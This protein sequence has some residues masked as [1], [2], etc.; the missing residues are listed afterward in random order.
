M[1]DKLSK[2]EFRHVLRDRYL[3]VVSLLVLLILFVDLVS[4]LGNGTLTLS[5]LA[6]FIWDGLIIGLALGLAG[7][8]L[9]MTY[10]ILGFANVAHGDTMTAGAFVGWGVVFL[11]FGFGDAAVGELLLL[12]VGGDLFA[13]DLGISAFARPL[14]VLMGILLTGAITAGLAL[15]IDKY[16]FKPLRDASSL[17]VLIASVGVAFLLRY[18]IVFFY[19]PT[20]LQS[21]RSTASRSSRRADRRWRTASRSSSS[22]W[23]SG[24]ARRFCSRS[25]PTRCCLWSSPPC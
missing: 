12:G 8:G 18:A 10:S 3:E 7:I 11:I 5:R 16:V 17:I 25:T 13:S 6:T 19:K 23:R 1:S 9:S 2:T 20:Q 22:R 4:S 15:T 21:G 24:A 14:A